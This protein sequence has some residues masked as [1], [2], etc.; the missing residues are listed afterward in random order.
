MN[1]IFFGVLFALVSYAIHFSHVET[2]K[3]EENQYYLNLQVELIEMIN[4]SRFLKNSIYAADSMKIKLPF[5]EGLTNVLIILERAKIIKEYTKKDNL[6][7]YLKY[8]EE[9]KKLYLYKNSMPNKILD[10]SHDLSYDIIKSDLFNKS[11][12]SNTDVN[13]YIELN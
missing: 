5:S 7:Y 3:L 9:T 12:V 6:G 10:I 13:L 4:Y 11:N 2:K 8:T 1:K